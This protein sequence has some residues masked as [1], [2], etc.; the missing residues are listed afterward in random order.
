MNGH[1]TPRRSGGD[2]I[3]LRVINNYMSPHLEWYFTSNLIWQVTW[4][5]EEILG[6]FITQIHYVFSEKG[7][8]SL[9]CN[10]YSFHKKRLVDYDIF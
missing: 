7:Q 2:R 9:V 6:F 5:Q 1:T 3:V 10:L 4:S 8:S